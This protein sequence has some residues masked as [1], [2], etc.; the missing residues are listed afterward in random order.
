MIVCFLAVGCG[1]LLGALLRFELSRLNTSSLPYG[2]LLVNSV[3]SFFI[4]WIMG[5]GLSM[6]WTLFWATGMA[7]AL[8]TY[9]TL[10]KEIWL[11]WLADQKRRA[12]V[13]TMFTFSLGMCLVY[14]GYSI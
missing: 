11:L 10:M 1:G 5:R 13:Y 2:T 4:G 3:G 7:G 8:T 9:S 14:I 12:I 6:E